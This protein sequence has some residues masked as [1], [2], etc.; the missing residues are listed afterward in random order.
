M[1][2][3]A[4]NDL[5]GV[6]ALPGVTRRAVYLDHCMVTFFDFEPGSI[7]PEHTHPHEQITYVVRGAMRFT[8]GQETRLLRA[9]EGVCIPS[10]VPHGAV[11]LD[12]PTVALDAWHPL[13]EDYR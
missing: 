11:I 5:P 8:L 4:V 10:G 2:F 3:F 6:A 9:H 12:E 13:R 1:T 7:I